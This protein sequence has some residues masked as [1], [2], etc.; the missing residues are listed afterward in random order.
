[1]QTMHPYHNQYYAVITRCSQFFFLSFHPARSASSW[2]GM[3]FIY[4]RVI[5]HE[6]VSASLRKP[7]VFPMVFDGNSTPWKVNWG[8]V[9]F[10]FYF[11]LINCSFESSESSQ[12]TSTVLKQL[13]LFIYIF[14]THIF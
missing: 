10:T 4:F 3:L 13:L 8:E 14:K 11:L 7:C 9:C 12:M 6:F 2:Q 1:M 5:S